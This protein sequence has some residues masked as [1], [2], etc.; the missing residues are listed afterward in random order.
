M[1]ALNPN[2]PAHAEHV[3][4]ILWEQLFLI[5]GERLDVG[6][7]IPLPPKKPLG[8]E[9]KPFG[10]LTRVSYPRQYGR[11]I[12]QLMGH[13]AK[14]ANPDRQT[15]L[16]S[17]LFRLIRLITRKDRGLE[18]LLNDIQQITGKQLTAN[19]D[20]LRGDLSIKPPIS[21]AR[22]K[23]DH[24]KSIPTQKTKHI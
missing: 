19:T 9:A 21:A 16:L 17:A 10:Y 11:L 12:V 8:L 20:E 13:V 14:E 7:N 3:Q 15:E 4:N 23:Y 1:Q 2:L 24:N 22:R 6:P 5:A 18:V